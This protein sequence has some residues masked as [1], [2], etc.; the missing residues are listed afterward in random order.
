MPCLI[1]PCLSHGSRGGST[2]GWGWG[3]AGGAAAPLLGCKTKEQVFKPGAHARELVYLTFIWYPPLLRLT[4]SLRDIYLSKPSSLLPPDGACFIL[5]RII[6]SCFF[7]CTCVL[8]RLETLRCFLCPEQIAHENI[9]LALPDKAKKSLTLFSAPL[10]GIS[11]SA[12]AC[13]FQIDLPKP[14]MEHKR[15]PSQLELITS[16][17]KTWSMMDWMMGYKFPSLKNGVGFLYV[18]NLR[19]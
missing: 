12:I 16:V 13:F 14:W 5:L 7:C 2:G 15:V 9:H 6:V 1:I 3:C 19:S 17:K 4:A 8:Q 18:W 10:W 11:G